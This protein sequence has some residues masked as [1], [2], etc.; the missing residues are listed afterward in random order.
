M[1]SGHLSTLQE[2]GHLGDQLLGPGISHRLA[3]DD[4][5]VVSFDPSRRDLVKRRPKDP[6][7]SVPL[8]RATDPLAG[9]EGEFSRAGRDEQHDPLPVNQLA[10]T[11][12]PLD[13]PR[14]HSVSR[15]R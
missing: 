2:L 13:P 12:D 15:K 4:D 6:P 14:A 10:V 8:H 5:D 7:G 1:S 3:G 9:D 11:E